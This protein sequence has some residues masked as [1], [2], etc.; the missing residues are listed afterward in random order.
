MKY[1]LFLSLVSVLFSF[2]CNPRK[3]N[4]EKETSQ[5]DN[6]YHLNDRLNTQ[7]QA[8]EK[9]MRMPILHLYQKD[10]MIQVKKESTIS[11]KIPFKNNGNDDLILK[12]VS[13]NCGCAIADFPKEPIRAGVENYIE[14]R[15]SSHGKSIR[16]ETQPIVIESNSEKK[17]AKFN[18]KI[19]ISE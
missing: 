4:T 13:S 14:V 1:C 18:I 8:N 11:I 9:K 2:S 19:I 15:Y 6:K 12:N 17:F 3:S 10:T 7:T 5:V 16:Q